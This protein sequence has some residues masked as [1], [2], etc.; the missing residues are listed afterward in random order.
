MAHNAT[1]GLINLVK[2]PLSALGAVFRR[3]KEAIV[4]VAT[5]M[6]N[7]IGALIRAITSVGKSKNKGLSMFD[8]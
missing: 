3:M 7:G 4:D 6:K 5:H 2:D 8:A 1:Q